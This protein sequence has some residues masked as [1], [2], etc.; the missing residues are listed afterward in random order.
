MAVIG[1]FDSCGD[2]EIDYRLIK[3]EKSLAYSHN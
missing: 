2:A 1:D 3:C